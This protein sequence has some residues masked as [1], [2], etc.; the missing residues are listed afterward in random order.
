MR[1]IDEDE[2]GLKEKPLDTSKRLQQNKTRSIVSAGKG[3]DYQLC[4]YWELWT[5][6][7][8]QVRHA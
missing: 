6:R 5:R 2:V 1:M 7:K 4:D 8:V 3:L